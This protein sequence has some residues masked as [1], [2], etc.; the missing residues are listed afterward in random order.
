MTHQLAIIGPLPPPFGGV[1][2]HLDRFLPYLDRA[3]IDYVVYNTAGPTEIPGRVISVAAN[4]RGWFLRYVLRG[5]EPVIY[6]HN[7]QWQAWALAWFLSRVRQKKVVIC[8]HSERVRILCESR[9]RFVSWLMRRGI[10]SADRLVVVSQRL[11]DFLMGVG[12]LASRTIVAPAF[13][14]PAAVSPGEQETATPP[15]VRDFCE[16]HHP[17]ILATGAPVMYQHTTDL[18][19]IDMTIELT[20]S[21]RLRYPKIGV[22]WFLLDFIGSIPEYAEKMRREV[23]RRTL[24]GHW[25]F[26]S[27]QKLFYPVYGLADLLVRPTCTDGDAITIREALHY[28][29]PVVAS[30]ATA[31]PDGTILFRTRDQIDYEQAVC[32]TLDNLPTERERLRH[33]TSGCAADRIIEVLREV[34][35]RATA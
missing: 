32:R 31:R 4:K 21:L 22:L 28:G 30:D 7:D 3:G 34:I 18:Y 5:R 26:A 8:F 11:Y 2:A 23:T 35:G 19:G 12:D 14:P 6:I 9:C 17:L 16:R 25:L 27:P 10:R 33:P 29:V 15:S 13:I 20:D 1:S 24:D